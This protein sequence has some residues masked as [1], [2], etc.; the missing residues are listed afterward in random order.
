MAVK[1][2]K[3]AIRGFGAVVAVAAAL[4]IFLFLPPPDFEIP[5][6]SA[7]SAADQKYLTE[8]KRKYSGASRTL[9]EAQARE[10]IANACS[11]IEEA[12]GTKNIYD[13]PAARELLFGT[14]CTE[15][16]LR[17][18]FQDSNGTAI[19]MFQVEFAT[20]KDLWNRAIKIKH[21]E[22]YSAIAGKYSTQNGGITFEDL[23][24]S[25][26]LCAVFAR[27]K[28]AE[29]NE[30]IP[31]STDIKAQANYYKKHY[32][33]RLGK[34]KPLDFIKRRAEVLKRERSR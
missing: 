2:K 20:F 29:N 9:S 25:D 33:T 5:F 3:K 16:G 32:N 24:T 11:F 28:Y 8:L 31:P 6:S 17:P 12:K 26:E 19:G 30:P 27:M 7:L 23:Q 21:P 34:A 15:S 10:V 14:A 4:W 22:L 18:R 13:T 1:K